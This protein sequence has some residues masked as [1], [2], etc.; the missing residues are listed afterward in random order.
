MCWSRYNFCNEVL[1]SL[2]MKTFQDWMKNE[3]FWDKFDQVSDRFANWVNQFG[4]EVVTFRSRNMHVEEVA[5]KLRGRGYIVLNPKRVEDINY[6]RDLYHHWFG[7]DEPHI[8][9]EEPLTMDG[10]LN[11]NGPST[12]PPLPRSHQKPTGEVPPWAQKE[13]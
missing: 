12:P 2:V 13:S 6:I 1:D 11:P 3:G 4:T 5:Q 10:P 7:E 8:D 9:M